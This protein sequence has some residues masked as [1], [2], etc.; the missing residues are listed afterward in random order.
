ME[1]NN[2]S[3]FYNKEGSNL[4]DIQSFGEGGNFSINSGD[5]TVNLALS[6]LRGVAIQCIEDSTSFTSLSDI[7]EL[8]SITSSNST[9]FSYPAGFVLYGNFVIIDVSNGSARVTLASERSN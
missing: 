8:S 2:G 5:G 3:V 6:G 7:S 1:N 9:D 4:Q